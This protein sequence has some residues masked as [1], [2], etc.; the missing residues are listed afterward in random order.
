MFDYYG[1]FWPDYPGQPDPR[2]LPGA[3][4]GQRPAQPAQEPASDVI[5]TNII[6]I[7]R[8]QDVDNVVVQSGSSQMFMT[9][10]ESTI[11]TKSRKANVVEQICYDR[12]KAEPPAAAFDLRAYPTREEVAQ[13]VDERLSAH[14]RAQNVPVNAF[15][16]RGDT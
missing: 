5:P 4:Y 14:Q 7:D 11:I 9:R 8:E 6:L 1:R 10:D 2:T 16:A 12:R 13:Y 3:Q 15:S